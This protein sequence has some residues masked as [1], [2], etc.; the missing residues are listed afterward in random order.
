MSYQVHHRAPAHS[1][2][3]KPVC[4]SV[5]DLSSFP[6]LI[7]PHPMV[8]SSLLVA[9]VVLAPQSPLWSIS[10]ITILIET[11]FPEITQHSGGLEEK[12]VNVGLT[13][14]SSM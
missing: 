14:V 12:G 8:H 13:K 1:L 5:H 7:S 9:D 3:V 10:I 6:G 11:L 4:S 2:A